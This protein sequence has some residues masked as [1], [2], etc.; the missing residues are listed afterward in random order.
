MP[1][2][3]FL[4]HVK[5]V[6]YKSIAA[7]DV[8]L[9]QVSFLVGPNGSG[10]GNFMDA[11]RFVADAL[12][13]SLDQALRVR[14]GVE[15]VQRK[16]RGDGQ[17]F[18]LHL[19]FELGTGSGWYAL[20][21]RGRAGDGYEVCREECRLAES[22]GAREHFFQ[23]ERGR[24]IDASIPKAPAASA[25]RLYLVTASGF[26]EFRPAFDALAGMRFA[27]PVPERMRPIQAPGNATSLNR[28]C[29]NVASVL[30]SLEKRS[31]T[32]KRHIDEYLGC[33]VPGIAEVRRWPKGTDETL[34][35]LLQVDDGEV[36]LPAS[37]MSDGTLR[38]L[39]VLVALFQGAAQKD[40]GRQLV[41]IE[42]PEA[43]QHPSAVEAL[44]DAIREAALRTQVIATSHSP[45]LLE[46]VADESII[47]VEAH[48]G[49]TR[50]GTLDDAA[51]SVIRDRLFTA[52]ELL[53]IDQLG[54]E[55]PRKDLRDL[56]ASA[57]A[58]P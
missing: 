24:V 41:G 49:A 19:Q 50:F 12:N 44:T 27:S 33:L 23:I 15:L 31:P 7:A 56:F 9:P 42:E 16:P 38:A 13:T 37:S 14:G 47:T 11:L 52:G 35:F 48:Q 39:G 4:T 30:G 45:E 17:P 29:S 5:L 54:M 6:N 18:G 20:T 1:S 22:R 43:G 2:R 3:R 58:L 40:A 26:E 55:E 21:I 36:R 10:K 51:R 25:D 53:R 46:G 57:G 32:A 34:G 8:R 28:D